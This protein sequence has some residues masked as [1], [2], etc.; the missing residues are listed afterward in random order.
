MGVGAFLAALGIMAGAKGLSALITSVFAGRA[1]RAIKKAI[2]EVYQIQKTR[3][4]HEYT[5]TR[6]RLLEVE[7]TVLG[8]QSQAFGAAG[9]A[10]GVGTVGA[11][12]MATTEAKATQDQSL[13]DQQY[14]DALADLSAQTKLAKA[15]LQADYDIAIAGIVTGY[16]TEMAGLG[17]DFLTMGMGLKAPAMKTGKTALTATSW[18]LT[19]AGAQVGG[20]RGQYY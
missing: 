16:I 14:S 6:T 9:H 20:Q 8:V 12:V 13:L 5:A 18:G 4:E 3:L 11:T 10:G 1:K 7:Q 19:G 15:K 17:T 2:E